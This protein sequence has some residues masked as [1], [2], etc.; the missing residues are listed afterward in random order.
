MVLTLALGSPTC[1]SWCTLSTGAIVAYIDG[2]VCLE[3][4][5]FESCHWKYSLSF[6]SSTPLGTIRYILKKS[7]VDLTFPSQAKEARQPVC[8]TSLRLQDPPP[9]LPDP[10]AGRGQLQ[11]ELS[12]DLMFNSD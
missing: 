12:V 5:I 7:S 11:G 8:A 4:R 3:I 2:Y 10:A 6:S 9:G 1:S